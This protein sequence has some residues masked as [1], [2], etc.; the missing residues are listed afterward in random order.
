MLAALDIAAGGL[1]IYGA[2]KRGRAKRRAGRLK[3]ALSDKAAK[4]TIASAQRVSMEEKRQAELIAS[5][6]LAVAAAS[7]GG[8]DD[9][10]VNKIIADIK[11]EGAYR[12][13]VAMYEGESQ[14][15]NLRLEGKLAKE[16]GDEAYKQTKIT[17]LGSLL[18]T[19][20]SMYSKYKI[21]QYG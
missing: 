12:A 21:G 20:A 2:R 5:R 6:A 8:A 1:D 19:G 9:P 18:E 11:G 17:G 13:A 15:Q 3:K 10:T 4:E 16:A 14:A 7:G